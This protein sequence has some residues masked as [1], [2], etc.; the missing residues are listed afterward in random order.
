M[1][2]RW[3]SGGG[4]YRQTRVAGELTVKRRAASFGASV[5][6]ILNTVSIRQLASRCIHPPLQ[7]R[8]YF[9]QCSDRVKVQASSDVAL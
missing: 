6:T 1:M 5:Y 9:V 4:V 8:V 2:A 3:R 7:E